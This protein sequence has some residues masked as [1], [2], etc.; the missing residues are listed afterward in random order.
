MGNIKFNTLTPEVLDENNKIY[1]EALD[2]AFG[3]NDIKI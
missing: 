1:T 3:N 2:Y